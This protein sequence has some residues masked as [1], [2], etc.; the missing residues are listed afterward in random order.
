MRIF[1]HASL[2]KSQ[3]SF[4]LVDRRKPRTVLQVPR[5]GRSVRMGNHQDILRTWLNT[6]SENTGPR[7][8]A[9]HSISEGADLSHTS[10]KPFDRNKVCQ[11][12]GSRDFPT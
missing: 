11:G 9:A 12:S 10:G 7:E 4:N 3:H 2:Q 1:P 6:Q 8:G 5:T